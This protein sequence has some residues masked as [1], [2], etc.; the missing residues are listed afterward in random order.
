VLP[1]P[2]H[3]P[4]V[5]LQQ[6]G[7]LEVTPDIRLDLVSPKIG[8][9]L[10]PSAMDGATMPETTIDEDNQ[11]DSGEDDVPFTSWSTHYR[12]IDSISKPHGK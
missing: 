11:F 2:D 8:I 1:N 6:S 3:L 5:T 12:K 10:R 9:G 7:R 4:T